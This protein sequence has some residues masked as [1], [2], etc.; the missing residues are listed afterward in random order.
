MD[1]KAIKEDSFI[2]ALNKAN[3]ESNDF[4]YPEYEKLGHK[5]KLALVDPY[6]AELDGLNRQ[7]I[8][9]EEKEKGIYKERVNERSE[10][11]Y[12]LKK[13]RDTARAEAKKILQQQ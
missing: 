11:E 7:M 4:V 2:D 1:K 3:I 10:R 5:L 9:Q 13:M 8:E 6:D 12:E